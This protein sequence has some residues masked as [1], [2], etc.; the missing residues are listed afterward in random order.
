VVEHCRAETRA[1]WIL[2]GKTA[3][4]V[5]LSRSGVGVMLAGAGALIVLKT[6]PVGGWK[7]LIGINVFGM[8]CIT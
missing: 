7:E 6:I 5:E 4:G 8:R 2:A 3:V 1:G